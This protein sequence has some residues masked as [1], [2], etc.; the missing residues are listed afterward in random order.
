MAFEF[1]FP[2]I[3]E[4]IHE[5]E[6]VK[7]LVKEGDVVKSD[8]PLGEIETDKAIAE[9]PSPRDGVI[10]KLNFKP[11]DT[12]KVGDVMVVIGEKGEKVAE[13]SRAVQEE[14]P[15]EEAKLEQPKTE[16][17]SKEK[18]ESKTEASAGKVLATP[19]VRKLAKD[20]GVDLSKVKG[21]GPDGRITEEDVKG[22]SGE[23]KEGIKPSTEKSE[24][25]FK[26]PKVTFEKYGEALRIPIRGMRKAIAENMVR[27]ASKI[28]HV[29][30]MDEADITELVKIREKE[31][32]VAENFGVKLTYLPFIIKAL[33]AALKEHPYLNSSIDETTNEI[34]V[35]K[36][37][38]IG[39]AVQTS[40]GLMVFVVKKVDD[41]SII[42]LARE[43][44]DL[45]EKARARRIALEDL[46]GGSF[47]ITNYGS[48]G[49]TFGTP[50]INYPEAAILGVGRIQEK[51]VVKEGKVVIRKILPLSL[52]FDHRIVDGA[53]AAAFMNDLIKRLEDPDELLI[54]VD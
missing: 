24:E 30:H 49:G 41:K 18:P 47:T 2:D 27:S 6:L 29:T 9:I 14:K 54:Y 7:W 51:P 53:E 33:L 52:T 1:R 43:I 37:Y 42:E 15:K 22:F 20:L 45:S 10:L 38:N 32:K 23:V 5:G 46:Q 44:Q 36:Y 31:K 4:G 35:K 8:Q 16:T 28:P 13:K 3:G 19:K 39:I 26:R 25:E 34:V 11:G 12:I 21:T 40:D 17:S 50:I 48:V